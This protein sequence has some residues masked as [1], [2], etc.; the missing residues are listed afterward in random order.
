MDALPAADPS[1]IPDFIADP[2][3]YGFW[4]VDLFIFGAIFGSFYNVC[5]YRIPRQIPLAMPPSHCYRCGQTIHWY[6]NIPLLSWWLLGGRCRYCRAPFSIRYFLIELLTAVLFTLI[7]IRFAN[8]R[9][10]FSLAFIPGLV[11]VSLLIIATFTD[12]DHWII[13]DRISL[14]GL[15]AGLALSLIWPLS[16]SPHHPLAY[17]LPY[18]PLP[19]PVVPFANAVAGAAVGYGS[20]WAIAVLGRIIFRKEAMGMGDVKLMAMFGSFL[21][22]INV[23]IAL[24][25]ACYIGALAGVLGLVLGWFA[26]RRPLPAPIAPLP[27]QPGRI[28][29]FDRQYDLTPVEI[30]VLGQAFKNPG[31]VR[32]SRGRILPFGPSLALA[33]IIVFLAWEPIWAWFRGFFFGYDAY[34]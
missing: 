15:G 9:T 16:A 7:F 21:G 28:D 29:Q 25:I 14:G 31:R 34:Y 4:I 32:L 18:F 10:G 11:F 26:E 22:P 24:L 12:L 2:F 13:P 5:I 3:L 19:E 8:P 33:A 20:L 30:L 27:S 17:P 1:S 6:D 23:L